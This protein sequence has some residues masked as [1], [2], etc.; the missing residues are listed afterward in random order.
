[1]KK[2]NI[3]VTGC[4]GDIGQSIGKILREN[5]LFNKVIGSDIN[6]EHAGK[7]IF[8]QIIKIPL[9]TSPDYFDSLQNLIKQAK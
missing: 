4:G 2:Y 7:F 5:A 1:M 3:L 9:C 8:D 6:D